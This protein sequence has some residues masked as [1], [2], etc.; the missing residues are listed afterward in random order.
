[1]WL[2]CGLGNIGAEYEGTRHN[3]G[4]EFIDIIV[5]DIGAH[6]KSKSKGD[7]AVAKFREEEVILLRPNTY[8]NRSGDSVQ[9]ISSFFKVP[10]DRVIVVHDDLDLS[11]GDVRV[12]KGGGH[13]G[14]NGL[15]DIDQ[16]MGKEYHRIRVGI[17]HPRDSSIPLK[18]VSDYVL[19][20]FST[21]E[22][23]GVQDILEL[24]LKK[25]VQII[26]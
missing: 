2:I 22:R 25:F 11:F 17:G 19:G 9:E 15:R 7:Y 6:F 18:S 21:E 24:A 20:K 23:V 12:K 16:K 3:I 5:D 13:A 8:M 1:M 10:L 26:S 14:H 4:F